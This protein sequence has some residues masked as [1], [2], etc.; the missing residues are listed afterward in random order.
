ME[1]LQP[2]QAGDASQLLRLVKQYG[3]AREMRGWNAGRGNGYLQHDAEAAV[4]LVRI[5]ALVPQQPVPRTA[6]E[7][8]ARMT[9]G[10]RAELAEGDL[11]ASE[12]ADALNR[13]MQ[14]R[15]L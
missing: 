3:N 4:L 11:L 7:I 6:A 1:N 2:V 15:G 9:Q 8:W 12:M 5:A 13:E 14:E 10:Q